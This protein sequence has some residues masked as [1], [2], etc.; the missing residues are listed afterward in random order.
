M[1]PHQWSPRRMENTTNPI[2]WMV[3]ILPHQSS[4]RRMENEKQPTNQLDD[5]EKLAT[6]N[7][8]TSHIQDTGWWKC[9]HINDRHEGWKTGSN[10][11]IN[12]MMKKSSPQRMENEKQHTN[13][14]DNK[15]KIATKNGKTSHIQDTGWWK[16]SHTNGA[17]KLATKNG[18][19]EATYQSTG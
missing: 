17:P 4:P 2:Y 7:G 19:R 18:K 10:L 13:Q 9:P 15:E 14:L 3:K 6:K 12:W 5:K 16:Y 1:P 11:P 8:K